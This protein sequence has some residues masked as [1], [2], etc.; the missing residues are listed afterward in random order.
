MTEIFDMKIIFKVI[1][2]ED[3]YETR[4][5][6][7]VLADDVVMMRASEGIE[8][9]DVTFYRELHSP[10]ECKKLIELVIEK[11][12]KGEEITFENIECKEED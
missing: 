7:V 5:V 11:T 8:P 1:K 3:D 9:E 10:F 2:R 4:D 6:H 12:K